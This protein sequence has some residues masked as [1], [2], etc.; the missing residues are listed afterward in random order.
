MA[1]VESLVVS[2]PPQLAA[3]GQYRIQV[4]VALMIG[5]ECHPVPDPEGIGQVAVQLRH[6]PSELPRPIGINPKLP[7][8]A[9]AVTLPPGRFAR[10]HGR[11]DHR[12]LIPHF[13][14]K[15]HRI[16]RP[17]RQQRPFRAVRLH[18]IGP[19]E[20][21][22]R[23]FECAGDQHISCGRE[24]L[25]PCPLVAKKGQLPEVAAVNRRRN[26]LWSIALHHRPDQPL[27]VRAEPRIAGR[28]AAGK[29]PARPD[30]PQAGQ[31]R[32]RPRQQK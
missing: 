16:H 3:V 12:T 22:F 30:R 27:P 1:D 24:P 14:T 10:K 31:A 18:G 17:V 5:E 13:G 11:E 20:P 6:Q 2:V 19:G 7:C 8:C 21:A 25:D 32:H 4:A 26:H 29:T 28:Q 9:A 15:G 23:L